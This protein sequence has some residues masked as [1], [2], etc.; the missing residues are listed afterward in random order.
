M[1]DP[2]ADAVEATV[3]GDDALR[4]RTARFVNMALGQAEQLML[5]DVTITFY[6]KEWKGKILNYIRRFV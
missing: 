6:E 5:T 2:L 3:A 4:A 1:G